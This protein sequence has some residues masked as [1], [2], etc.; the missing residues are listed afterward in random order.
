MQE[1]YL[2]SADLGSGKIALT[3]AKVVG[4]DVQIIYYKETPSDGI[5]YSCV[6]NPKRA[7]DALRAAVSLAEE[8]LKIKIYQLLVGLP[9]YNV[10][11][12]IASARMERTDPGSCIT[13]EEINVLKSKALDSYP[14]DDPAKENIYGAVVQ[15]FS[16]DDLVQQ[17]EN[18]VVGATADVLEG[19]FK[20]FVGAGKAEKNIDI[21]CNGLEIAS[22]KM[23]LPHSV[24]K[25][26]L[27]DVEKENGVALVEIGAGVTS[28]TIYQGKILRY[29]S[30]IPFGGKSITNDIKFECGFKESL[31]ENIKI[32]FGACMPGKLQSMSEKVLQITDEESGRT[33]KLPL[34]YLSEII[35]S[36]ASEIIEAVLFCIQE[37]GFAE[38]LRNGIVITGGGANLANLS[39]LI[40]EMSGYNV[41]IGYP[42]SRQFSA[43][44]CPG[45]TETG[46]VASVG[47]ILDAARDK[48]LNCTLEVEKEVIAPEP[49]QTEEAEE[50]EQPAYEGTVFGEPEEILVP[51]KP[52]HVKA[53]KDKRTERI[54]WTGKLEKVGSKLGNALEKTFG[55]LFDET[56]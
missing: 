22:R 39:A 21:V 38:R 46:A 52:R 31:A 1:R 35:T 41:R 9:R 37:S 17:S 33:D 45:I 3:V 5:R 43:E 26:V 4:E 51:K 18:D 32:A 48:H 8:E 47:M 24:A 7:E 14:L 2:A 15:S 27:T 53:P 50:P 6:Y 12:E 23:F 25:A 42:R 55:D 34:K 30:A 40:R 11:Q 44:G 49:S 19:N 36:R 28:L 56:K 29:Y 20:V 16:A 10:R 54:T 13:Q